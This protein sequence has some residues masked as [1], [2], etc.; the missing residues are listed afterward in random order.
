MGKM[1]ESGS[2]DNIREDKHVSFRID[3]ETDEFLN[4]YSKMVGV[5]KTQLFKDSMLHILLMNLGNNDYPNPQSIISQSILHY[6][7]DRC[8]DD[9]LVGAGRTSSLQIVD[10]NLNGFAFQKIHKLGGIRLSIES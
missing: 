7:F 9:N 4:T 2:N 6:L 8:K 1:N 5:N 3:P 10:T